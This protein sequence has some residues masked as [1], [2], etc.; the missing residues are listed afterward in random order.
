MSNTNA[1]FKTTEKPGFDCI[2]IR[3]GELALK[4]K[5]RED[6]EQQLYRNIKQKM[7]GL[8]V[9]LKKTRGRLFLYLGDVSL[10]EV[11]HRL[12]HLF[13]ISSYSPAMTV[14]PDVESIQ[15]GALQALKMI[16]P[17]P[18][19]FK[20]SVKRVNKRFPFTS[21]EMN[22]KVGGYILASSPQIAVDVHQPDTEIMIEIRDDAAYI[23]PQKIKGA[24]GL[25]VGS[26]GKV[27]LLL[28]GG[29]DSPVAG[30][31]CLKRGL[32]FEGVHF[33]SFPFTSERAKQKAI[34]LARQLAQYAGKIK[35][36]IV[37]FTTIQTEI[38]KNIP[39]SY[40]ITIMRR[41]MMRIA[42]ELAIKNGALGL[43]TGESLGQVASQ[44]IE[45]M[46]TINEVTN[47]PVLRP[48]V[49]M[50][51]VEIIDIAQEIGTYNISILPY[52]D[53]CTVFQ[54]KHPKTKPNRSTARRLE[55]RLDI[56][57][58]VDQAVNETETIL[59]EPDGAD[60]ELSHLF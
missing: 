50:D 24:G 23:M 55:E 54:P 3:L 43:A 42:E 45:S 12:K 6:F 49:T 13:G 44:T 25:P 36:H 9:K 48:L 47:F 5:N 51:K 8:D 29:I 19:T 31:L 39:D 53:C 34:D 28:S 17:H 15:K 1:E 30:Y 37:P 58:L 40:G 16:Q 11:N 59:I 32:R 26:S 46:H 20:V 10:D 52:E 33:H 14:D 38:K 2:L 57:G 56:Q 4:G 21:L 22:H 18:Q 27:M 7:E 60:Q 35:L 41:M